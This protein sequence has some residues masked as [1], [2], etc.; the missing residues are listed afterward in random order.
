MF[1]QE[2]N[3]PQLA[4]SLADFR[5]TTANFQRKARLF[6]NGSLDPGLFVEI[7]GLAL[8]QA[9]EDQF[10]LDIHKYRFLA[11]LKLQLY[12]EA[13]S[14][15]IAVLNQYHDHYQYYEMMF[16]LALKRNQHHNALGYLEK[17]TDF[18]LDNGFDPSEF[19]REKEEL[20]KFINSIQSYALEDLCQKILA[21]GDQAG[22]AFAGQPLL[23]TGRARLMLYPQTN[24][25]YLLFNPQQ[26]SINQV[27][28]HCPLS[29]V[30]YLRNVHPNLDIAV[31]GYFLK[32]DAQKLILKP[33]N[34]LDSPFWGESP[35]I[36]Q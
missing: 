25:P 21:Q 12:L 16:A 14:D 4:V 13:A 30:P 34:L 9:Q 36:A 8:E 6:L 35:A 28:C 22:S 2:Q 3:Y 20:L 32:A 19:N 29:E 26:S 1:E 10:R 11:R 24:E 18:A 15:A 7:C 17:M 31:F 5:L 27:Y 23:I 33:C